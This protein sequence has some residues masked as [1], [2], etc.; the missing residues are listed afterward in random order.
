MEAEL[1]QV[2]AWRQ[3]PGVLQVEAHGAGEALRRGNVA[4]ERAP[5]HTHRTVVDLEPSDGEGP[6]ER[7]EGRYQGRHCH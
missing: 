7:G 6:E 3:L 1:G 5:G 4:P 2:V